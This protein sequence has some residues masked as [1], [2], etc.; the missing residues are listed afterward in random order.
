MRSLRLSSASAA[1]AAL[2]LSL[3]PSTAAAQRVINPYFMF[4]MDSSGSMN[5]G[6]TCTT[7]TT[8]ACGAS[9]TRMNDAKCALAR[10]VAGTGDATFGLGQFSQQ[11]KSGCGDVGTSVG[12][13]SC[14]AGI[15]AGVIR[16]GIAEENQAAITSLSKMKCQLQKSALLLLS[17]RP[18]LN[19][20]RTFSY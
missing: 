15:A 9:C 3:A 7:G 14:S 8:N 19:S 20:E 4:L 16:V 2:I 6:T 10:V 1:F 17:L 18:K 12:Q 13:I 5:A 11:C